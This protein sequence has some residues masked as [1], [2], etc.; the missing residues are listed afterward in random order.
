MVDVF[1]LDYGNTELVSTSTLCQAVPIYF[2]SV[3]VELMKCG[4]AG[5]RPV[6]L[7]FIFSIPHPQ[8]QT[9]YFVYKLSNCTNQ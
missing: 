6:S 9:H 1:Y 7:T 2:F 8:S 4:L 5:I 3:N